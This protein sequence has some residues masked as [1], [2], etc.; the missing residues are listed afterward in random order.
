MWK[1]IGTYAEKTGRGR[2]H[3][4]VLTLWF[5]S[6]GPRRFA[7]WAQT[8]QRWSG[9]SEA[10]SHIAQPE[11]RQLE[12][13]T[14]YW[15]TLVRRRRRSR[16]SSSSRG[17]RRK[18]KIGK[19]E[20]HVAI[21]HYKKKR[22]VILP[23]CGKKRKEKTGEGWDHKLLKNEGERE[24]NWWR[25]PR[26]LCTLRKVS[27]AILISGDK[28]DNHMRPFLPLMGP[29]WWISECR[30]QSAPCSVVSLWL[31]VCKADCQ[32]ITKVYRGASASEQH[33]TGY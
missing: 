29:S 26:L 9:L 1:K 5:G 15:G 2:P 27:K 28:A 8:W 30:R 3:G 14:T 13:T 12:Y 18:Q 33:H 25:F 10:E 20:A 6:P 17:R 22:V 7:S 4:E 16:S 32:G 19:M 24:G 31:E 11:D 23:Y 21:F